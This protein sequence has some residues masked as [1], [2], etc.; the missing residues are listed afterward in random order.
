M[1]EMEALSFEI[2]GDTKNAVDSISN[3]KR[4]LSGLSKISVGN[5]ANSM[6]GAAGAIAE[7][8]QA[9][10]KIDLNKCKAFSSALKGFGSVSTFMHDVDQFAQAPQRLMAGFELLH[11]YL[12]DFGNI[13]LSNLESAAGSIGKITKAISKMNEIGLKQAKTEAEEWAD[14]MNSII[15]SQDKGAWG[16]MHDVFDMSGVDA[17]ISFFKNAISG[18]KEA[19]KGT[20]D[21]AEEA[22]P[23]VSALKSALSGVGSAAKGIAG[24]AKGGLKALFGRLTSPVADLAGKVKTLGSSLARI[25]MYRALRSIIKQVTDALKQGT[26]NLYNW[27][28]AVGGAT[29][30]GKTFADTMNG[31]SSA[32]AYLKNSIGAAVAPFISALAPAIDFAIGKIVALINVINQLMALL[33]GG[34]GWNKATYNA[35]EF[36]KAA[37]GGGGAAKEALKYLAPFDELNVLPDENQGGGGG[38][39]AE[40]YEDMFEHV[41]E[42]SEKIANFA[43][44]VK[45]A[46]ASGDWHDVGVFMGEK[47]NEAIENIPWANLG[48]TLGKAINALIGT[49]YWNLK[50]IDFVNLGNKI[51][52]FLNNAME[53]IDF[54]VA[55]RLPVRELTSILDAII[56]A[57]EGLNWSLIGTSIHD[58]IVGALSEA[59]EWF[60]ETDFYEFGKS[61]GDGLVKAIQKIKLGDIINALHNLVISIIGALAGML[62]GL[63]DGVMGALLGENKWGRIK[64]KLGIDTDE[65]EKKID[66]WVNKNK[67][68]VPVEGK[69]A[70]KNS[71]K[72]QKQPLEGYISDL[73]T[74]EIREE[75]K[76][77]HGMTGNVETIDTGKIPTPQK[78]VTGVTGQVDK[79]DTDGVPKKEKQIDDM[80]GNLKTATDSL[81]KKDKIIDTTADMNHRDLSD[82]DT[83]IDT[84]SNFTDSDIN[85]NTV[86]DTIARFIDKKVNF[87]TVLDTIARFIDKTFG[88]GFSNSIDVIGRI[89]DAYPESKTPFTVN[90]I[91][92]IVGTIGSLFSGRAEGG[93]FAGGQWRGVKGYAMGGYPKG[94]QMFIAREAGPELVGTLG[95]HTAVMNNDQIVASVSAGVARAISGISFQM[96]GMPVMA[97]DTTEPDENNEDAMYRAFSRALSEADLDH[98]IILDGYTI[99]NAMVRRNRLEQSRTGVNPMTA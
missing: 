7:F 71:R 14:K 25:A 67:I 53:N 51:A 55:G 84:T 98:D 21:A 52:E 48:A 43:Q 63:M 69:L 78:T 97:Y 23:K 59:H 58:F 90:V 45:D 85:F 10:D 49:E 41:E 61:L 29:I 77:L 93:V 62:A 70:N 19:I 44:M 65:I 60:T 28:K 42:F 76:K 18:A 27:S 68:E 12:E 54:N 47:I 24:A 50:T 56:G 40:A 36:G 6:K 74:D 91:G 80:T 4:A 11:D 26:T 81:P 34:M 9:L 72:H 2:I 95:G 16:N 99:Y 33:G 20:G 88:G 32:S 35:K 15:E 1:A 89:K 57:L 5:V 22:A 96:S 38:G 39:A 66:D 83:V 94:S 8:A 37:A 64:L 3:L 75:Q 17:T 30:K 13:D 46:W 92:R 79:L 86:I 82:L 87:S 31:L 73:S